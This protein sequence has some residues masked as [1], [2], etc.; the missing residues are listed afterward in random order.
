MSRYLCPCATGN[1][2]P[3]SPGVMSDGSNEAPNSKNRKLSADSAGN[4]KVSVEAKHS[5]EEKYPNDQTPSLSYPVLFQ[6]KQPANEMQP[7]PQDM[8]P[9]AQDMHPLPQNMSPP[10]QSMSPQPQDTQ[11][12]PD[13]SAVKSFPAIE[14]LSP[15]SRPFETVS[16][17]FEAA[18]PLFETASPPIQTVSPPIQTASPPIQ[19]AS[20][21]IQTASPPLQ[22]AS[23]P[24]NPSD[25][26]SSPAFIAHPEEFGEKIQ[27]SPTMK[28]SVDIENEIGE[29]GQGEDSDSRGSKIP[30]AKID[31]SPTHIARE[32]D[33][34]DFLNENEISP[35]T[36]GF[37]FTQ[38]TSETNG[39]S[40]R[41]VKIA[42]A[43]FWN[44]VQ[45][46]ADK[47]Q[48]I[49]NSRQMSRTMIAL[50]EHLQR[51]IALHLHL[52]QSG[53]QLRVS[54]GALLLESSFYLKKLRKIEKVVARSELTSKFAENMNEILFEE[55]KEFALSSK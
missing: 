54:E 33:E 4:L 53:R 15:Q 1:N 20:P 9:L 11:N 13:R 19:T 34:L 5:I 37:D 45:N 16:P 23:P 52:Q 24:I 47:L 28:L 43:H 29:S 50:C 21:H 6:G 22:T 48:N 31:L 38:W 51:L 17:L 55:S 10:P 30:I 40:D 2:Q 27:S 25:Y 32:T 49:L 44:R 8:Q 41:K 35:E 14:M 7:L 18:S 42:R 39:T 46:I 36:D 3:D 26:V 12:V